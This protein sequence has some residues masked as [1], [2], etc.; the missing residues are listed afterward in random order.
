V[1]PH[2]HTHTQTH[3]HK[4][5]HTNTHTH[6]HTKKST[7]TDTHTNTRTNTH[8]H[9]YIQINTHANTYTHTCD[10]KY[11]SLSHL[12]Y[13]AL[14]LYSK[15]FDPSQEVSL[16]AAQFDLILAAGQAF[17]FLLVITFFSSVGH[18]LL[19]ALLCVKRSYVVYKALRCYIY[20]LSWCVFSPSLSFSCF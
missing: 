3:T 16:V 19:V 18:K 15:W 14:E 5:T 2:T 6:T 11:R 13:F 17:K 7:H 12:Y 1:Y 9:E 10:L 8:T 20:V 4:H